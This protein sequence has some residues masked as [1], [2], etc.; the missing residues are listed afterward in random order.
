M[1]SYDMCT[2]AVS[3][4]EETGGREGRGG[5]RSGEQ[6]NYRLTGYSLIKVGQGASSLLTYIFPFNKETHNEKPN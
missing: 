2:V 6:F 1:S 3:H 4:G 5:G